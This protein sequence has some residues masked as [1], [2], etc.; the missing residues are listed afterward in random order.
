[1]KY[2]GINKECYLDIANLSNYDLI[3]G[4]P[5]WFQHK[6]SVGMNPACVVI[7]SDKALPIGGEGVA[8][9]SSWAM[10]AYHDELTKVRQ[11]LY[12]YALLICKE[13]NKTELPPL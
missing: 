8:K 6:V 1:L 3:L 5:W 11:E 12:E 4:T 2:Q 10:S 13:V 7:G 9:I